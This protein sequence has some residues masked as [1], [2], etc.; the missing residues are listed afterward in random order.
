M[1]SSGGVCG[2]SGLAALLV[3]PTLNVCLLVGICHRHNIG[4]VMRFRLVVTAA[5]AGRPLALSVA[6]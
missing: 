4:C 6:S 5:V 2:R 3:L 1:D